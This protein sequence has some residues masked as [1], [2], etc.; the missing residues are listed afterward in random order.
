[1]KRK[2]QKAPSKTN[3]E[4]Q[5]LSLWSQCIRT[6]DRVCRICGSDYRL[7]A[8]HIRSRGNKATY[9]DLENGM[10][11]C[12][13]CHIIQK[14]NPEKFQDTVLEVIGNQEYQRLKTKSQMVWKPTT[15]ELVMMK[16]ALK[17]SLKLFERDYG[18]TKACNEAEE[19][20]L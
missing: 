4:N 6:R 5:C 1:M 10:A 3:I 17:T 15:H 11:V 9:L 20:G 12:A 14:F 16:D 13:R 7:Q 2:K 8:H 18:I 19:A